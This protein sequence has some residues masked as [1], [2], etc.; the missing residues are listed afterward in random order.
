M[1]GHVDGVGLIAG[2]ELVTDKVTRRPIPAATNLGTVVDRIARKH[3]LIVRVIAN[4]LTF[5][6]P[7]VITSAEIDELLQRLKL[8]L[9]D[10]SVELHKLAA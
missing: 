1:V 8:T 2:M 9:D 5:S 10:T 7:L 4:R 3:G 6:P